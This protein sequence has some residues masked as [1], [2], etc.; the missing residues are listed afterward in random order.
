MPKGTSNVLTLSTLFGSPLDTQGRFWLKE[1][2]EN[3]KEIAEGED[4]RN[5]YKNVE[6]PRNDLYT[7]KRK[8]KTVDFEERLF[9]W[10]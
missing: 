8:R 7:Q 1:R 3:R 5:I 10:L 6:L 4:W 9:D 2:Q